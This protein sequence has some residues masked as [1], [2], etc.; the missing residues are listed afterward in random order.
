MRGHHGPGPRVHGGDERRQRG[1]RESAGVGRDPGQPVMGVDDGVAVAGEVLGARGDTRRLQP[2]HPGGGVPGD[3]I[4]A[5]PEG[6]HPDHRIQRVGVDV[7]ARRV[8]QGDAG[9]VQLPADVAGDLLGDIDVV[10]RAERKAARTGRPGAG[11]QPGDVARLLVHRDHEVGVLRVQ[12]GG[13]PRD[14]FRALDV[15]AE[16]DDGG[17][18]FGYPPAHPAGHRR[19]LEARLEHGVRPPQQSR[20]AAL[21]HAGTSGQGRTHAPG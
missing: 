20:A 9:G 16:Q 19:P 15:A 12:G 4:G 13:E 11:L 6:T 1:Q 3:D 10:Q 2:P 8:V 7:G 17:E 5:R 14:L 18:S 21:C